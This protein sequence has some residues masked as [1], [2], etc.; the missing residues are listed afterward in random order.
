MSIYHRSIWRRSSNRL[1]QS[2]VW[3]EYLCGIGLFIAALILFLVNLS[4]LP[5]ID[6]QE[7]TFAAVAKGIHQSSDL[8]DWIFPSLWNEPYL[9]KP[10]LIHILI[11]IAYR[12][13]GVNE[14]TTRFPGAL[15]G[16]FSVLLLYQIGREIFVTRLPALFSALVYL[17]CL[18]V[19]RYSRLATSDGPLLC[20]QLLT[21][22]AVLRS[23][24]NLKWALGTGIGFGLMSLTQS[25]FS[26]QFLS[27][28]LIFL[29]WDTPRLLSSAFF[30]A[31]LLIGAMPSFAWYMGL[32]V[33][34]RTTGLISLSLTPNEPSTQG[35]LSLDYYF[36]LG[37][38]YLVPWLAIAFA[39]LKPLRH[40]LQWGWAKLL[41]VWIGGYLIFALL[42]H[43]GNFW[44]V[45]PLYPGLALATGKQLDCI[46][47]LPSFMTYPPFLRYYFA[48][49]A[50]IAAFFG[51]NWGFYN[52]TDSYLPFICG[53]LCITFS[54]TAIFIAQRDQQFISLL[55]WGLLV[56]I[57][58]FV[59]SPHWIWELKA[60]PAI[61]PVAASIKQHTP[62]QAIIY[63][64]SA[65]ARPSLS[66]YSE[67]QILVR[68]AAELQAQWQ[69]ENM[70]YLLIESQT[71]QK[72]NL[73][74]AVV[75]KDKRLDSLGWV[76]AIKN[77]SSVLADI[78]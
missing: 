51:I 2:E 11:A 7:A 6:Y 39:G 54:A 61:K 13:G 29:L 21:V 26:L 27:L 36:L 45:V 16:A 32:F 19:V 31:G 59:V 44:L 37:V 47:N 24:R 62:P 72:L 1:R 35:S 25:W 15:L 38:Q 70:V 53:S 20:F 46:R 71:A 69:Q 67:R 8:I 64:S 18:P 76:L 52:Y 57:F 12:I 4:A 43:E 3:L 50:V 17:T 75:V 48:L 66:F 9:D 22:W 49:M 63:A 77:S 65:I 55:F 42:L 40:N 14:F 34:Y 23:R 73:A 56:S 28:L 60:T 58:L 68:S 41:A 78:F 5:L 74:E 30:W 33:Y 10:P